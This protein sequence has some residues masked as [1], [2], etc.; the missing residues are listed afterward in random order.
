[1]ACRGIIDEAAKRQA[2]DILVEANIPRVLQTQVC[3]ASRKSD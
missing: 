3:N 2:I 1:M